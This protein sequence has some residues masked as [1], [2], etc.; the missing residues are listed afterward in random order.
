MSLNKVPSPKEQLRILM[1][2]GVYPSTLYPQKGV[3]VKS[4][5]DALLAAGVEVEI[6][7]PRAGPTPLRYMEAVLQVF[8][9]TLTKRFDVVHGHYGLWCLVAR[10]Q[11]TTPVVASFLGSDLLG[12]PKAGGGYTRKSL[13]VIRVSRWIC[14]IVDIALVKS[15]QM[16]EVAKVDSI[17]V[18]PD[19]VD[20]TLFHPTPRIEARAALGWKQDCYYILFGNNPAI[21]RKNY[22]LAQDAVERLRNRGMPAEL[23]VASGLPQK[24]LNIY[25]NASDA[26]IVTSLHEG[27]PNGVKEAMACNIPVVSVD[28]GDVVQIIGRTQGCSICPH[29]PDALATAL[30]EALLHTQPTTGRCDIAHLDSSIVAKQTIAVYREAIRKT[31]KTSNY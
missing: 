4:Q 6:V 17:I 23:V 3:F 13:F 8:C 5:M 14:R 27:S 9:R 10:M 7:H 29:D 11:W 2:S 19:G 12:D 16:K 24:K 22:A 15:Q 18:M 21:P 30:Q 1:V 25:I 31:K 20:F 28:V 26:F